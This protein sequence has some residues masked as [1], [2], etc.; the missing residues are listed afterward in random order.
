MTSLYFSFQAR[1][2]RLRESGEIHPTE[3]GAGVSPAEYLKVL[4]EI[5]SATN[6]RAADAPN[7]RTRRL[8]NLLT[9]KRLYSSESCQ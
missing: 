5:H 1:L 8:Q 2:A 9:S 3:N 4:G 7:V 6:G